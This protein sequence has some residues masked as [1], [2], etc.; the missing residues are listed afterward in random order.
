MSTEQLQRVK[1]TRP[2]SY[3]DMSNWG[4]DSVHVWD[5]ARVVRAAEGLDSADVETRKQRGET[6]LQE[7]LGNIRL[8]R[9]LGIE[10]KSEY[11]KL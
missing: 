6:V 9:H 5:T 11:N 1:P 4:M 10:M 2:V 3:G 7:E 8:R